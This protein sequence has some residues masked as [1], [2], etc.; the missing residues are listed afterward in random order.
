MLAGFCAFLDLYATQPLLPLLSQ[1]F[2]ATEFAVSL[3]VTAAT[4]GVA[5]AAPVA[6]TISDRY[7]R[8]NTIVAAAALLSL[9]TL[10]AA[11]STGLNTLIFWRFLQGV[12]TPGIF[13]VTLAYI[14]DEWHG[15]ESAR[16]TAAYVT[17][18]VIGGFC[19][20]LIA[21]FVATHLN[22]HWVFIALGLL[23]AAGAVAMWQWLPR[24][25]H[26]HAGRLPGWGA[27]AEHLRNPQLL[28]TYA[29]G[30]CVLFSMTSAFTYITFYLAAAPFHLLP[31]SLGSLFFV[32]LIGAVITP[33]S[34]RW[35]D[36]FGQRVSLATAVAA[37]TGGVLLT[38]VPHLAVVIAGLAILCTGVFIAQTS[39][40]S[41]I[42]VA[43]GRNRALAVGLYVT[44]YYI[45]GSAGAAVPG[46]F[47]RAGGWTACVV[48]I[49]A[50]QVLT[51]GMALVLWSPARSRGIHTDVEVG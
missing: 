26:A 51:V 39:A 2:A 1:L 24:E 5:L 41:Y 37:G 48:L 12:A 43:T 8:K 23:N 7:G 10:L 44:F 30:F 18:T 6:G 33:A 13:A 38:L 47:W 9:F 31:A 11:S 46:F 3:T 36:R 20:R 45:G 34:G 25:R 35:I 50:V 42:G 29:V 15:T 14:H 17:G 49:A 21:G 16:A 19:G 40:T 4:F 32:Y 22:W 28:A 27:I